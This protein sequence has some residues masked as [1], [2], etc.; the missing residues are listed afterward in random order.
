MK[1][2]KNDTGR[3]ESVLFRSLGPSMADHKGDWPYQLGHGEQ[4]SA[5]FEAGWLVRA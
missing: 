3:E 1:D 5:T 2:G 4:A